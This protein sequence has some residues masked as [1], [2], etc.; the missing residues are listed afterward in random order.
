MSYYYPRVAVQLQ[1]L[2]ED[3]GLRSDPTKE[4]TTLINVQA[5][6]VTINRNDY[7]TSDTFSLEID[8]KNFPFDPRTIR[9]CGVVIYMQDVQS[10]Y[11]TDG[12]VKKIIP[13]NPTKVN[14]NISNAVFI[15]YA[16]DDEIQFD[17]NGRKVT[18][19]GRDSTCLLIDKKYPSTN[20]PF[21]PNLPLDKAIAQLLLAF[22]ATAKMVVVPPIGTDGKPMSLPVLSSYVPG[23]G[24]KLAGGINTGGGK[25]ETYWDIILD[26]ADRAGM[27]CYMGI[28]RNQAGDSV[29]A[30]YL[31]TPKNQSLQ[32]DQTTGKQR[33][34]T[35]DD[36]KIIY[37]QNV[38]N[39][40]FKRK[41]GRLKGFN[42]KVISRN[43]KDVVTAR[44]PEDANASWGKAY[45]IPTGPGN[46]VTIPTLLPNGAVDTT[47]ALKPAPY[48]TFP[49]PNIASKA[50]LV[51]IGQAAYEQYSLQQL[52][53]SFETF[54]MLGRGTQN[55][56]TVG[57]SDEQS[58]Q[59]FGSGT[60][61]KTPPDVVY[62]MTQIVKGQTLCIELDSPDLEAISRLSDD[63]D[64]TNYLVQ[65]S[66][67]PAVA[68]LFATTI[69]KMSPRFQVKSY[70][71]N[72]NVDS[73]FKLTVQFQNLIDNTNRSLT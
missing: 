55:S 33:T 10:N 49:Y 38:K 69:G 66:Y 22:P 9:A 62:D 57:S 29:A 23:F 31:S 36:I 65:R 50:A 37:G 40:K 13:G 71:M 26:L 39:L 53:G 43:G 67:D 52:E 15:G 16:D 59:M 2:P 14:P 34:D 68:A 30:I 24:D 44:I 20:G 47:Q 1:I 21:Y 35:V 6:D 41:I 48:I 58:Q 4:A 46:F 3:Y 19:S 11:D 25:R 18:M 28:S 5:R 45:G 27:V 54:E 73:G 64:R 17:D 72:I 70:A 8:Y 60:Q 12:S 61:I 63:S 51:L 32:I 42:I 7:R 56:L